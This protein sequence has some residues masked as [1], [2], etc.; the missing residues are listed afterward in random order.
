M[1]RAQGKQV[2]RIPPYHCEL[3]PI[4]FVWGFFKSNVRVK[5]SMLMA[6]RRASMN[7]IEQFATG[8]FNEMK[9]EHI[10][11]AFNHCHKLWRQYLDRGTPVIRTTPSEDDSDVDSS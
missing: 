5:N 2:L 9:P 10:Q 3:N 11:N 7:T 4:E 1:A 6:N 8:V